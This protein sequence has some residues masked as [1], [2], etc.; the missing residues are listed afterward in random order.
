MIVTDG[1]VY[2][3]A[4]VECQHP[5]ALPSMPIISTPYVLVAEPLPPRLLDSTPLDLAPPTAPQ[6]Q[7]HLCSHP[8]PVPAAA[9]AR[10]PPTPGA[11][12][13]ASIARALAGCRGRGDGRVG[14][15]RRRRRRRRGRGGGRSRL[16]FGG[17]ERVVG[18]MFERAVA[19]MADGWWNRE[20]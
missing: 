3:A 17:V 7:L 13:A 20:S 8:D 4:T 6:S 9:A 1:V 5:H 12:V 19:P 11:G 2:T 15:R 14:G 16:G 18:G 10:T